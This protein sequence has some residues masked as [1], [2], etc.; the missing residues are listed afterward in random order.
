M[1][2][3]PIAIA[4][5][6]MGGEGGGVLA[7]WIADMAEHAGYYAQTTSV[8]GVAQRTGS[9]IYYLEL[10][11]EGE[12]QPVL[13]L[14]PVP[15]E[16]D[17]V[18]ASELMEAGR[19]VQRG[20]VTPDRTTLVASSH[21]VYSMTERIDPGDGRVD[22]RVLMQAC[23]SAARQFL[24]ADF[25]RVADGAGS[26]ISAALFGGLAAANALPFEEARFEEA[27]RRSGI[28]VE[29]SL[30][31]FHRGQ[32]SSLGPI[33]AGPPEPKPEGC[34]SVIR[35]GIERLT[36]YQDDAYAAEYQGLLE[37]V[38]EADVQYGKPDL[39]L[40]SEA[41]RQL[42]LWMSYEDAIRVAELKI[43]GARLER[44]RR[45][46]RLEPGQILHVQEFLHP[47]LEELTDIMPAAAGRWLLESKW[48]RRA[49]DRLTRRGIRV[50]TTSLSGFLKL[51]LL[52]GLRRWRR[53]TLRYAREHA[54][55]RE[56]LAV[57]PRLARE[58]YELALEAARYP[59]MRRGYG[60]T[61]AR[62]CREFDQAMDALAR[63]KTTQIS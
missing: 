55:M 30:Q 29:A 23:R 6:A 43:R 56:W 5:L 20:L 18:I 3:R 19:A 12:R 28:G 50:E 16:V 22:S 37:P 45:E 49:V 57:L 21:R 59:E 52:A 44:V 35:L 27:I 58:N 41:A 15:G 38:R 32:I 14:M 46:T 31:A 63:P 4:I 53:R 51:R 13:A 11:P 60:A 7:D 1:S 54:R 26:V 36:D 8:P 9:T 48:A 40:L 34:E 25:A 10:F 24:V 17:I 62:G 47:G 33:S 2:E 61:H 39:P 42:A